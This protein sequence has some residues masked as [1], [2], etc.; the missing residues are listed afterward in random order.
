LSEGWRADVE[1]AALDDKGLLASPEWIKLPA[2]FS[3]GCER[4]LRS[5]WD[6]VVSSGGQAIIGQ[7]HEAPPGG[8]RER[9]MGYP[10]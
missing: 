4:S 8:L 7:K 5:T 1:V 6:Q 2:R 10:T 3:S 9:G